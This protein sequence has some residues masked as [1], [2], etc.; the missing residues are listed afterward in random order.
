MFVV[1]NILF[2]LK[3]LSL[4]DIEKKAPWNMSVLYE[5]KNLKEILTKNDN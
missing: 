4:P 2:S 5:Q 1:W 3:L